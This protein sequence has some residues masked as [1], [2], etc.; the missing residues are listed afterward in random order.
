MKPVVVPVNRYKRN[1]HATN[2]Q[3]VTRIIKIHSHL[4]LCSEINKPT[5]LRHAAYA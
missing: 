2:I 1:V 5:V 3:H 4:R